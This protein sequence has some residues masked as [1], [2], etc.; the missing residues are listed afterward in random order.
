MDKLAVPNHLWKDKRIPM[1]AK[2]VYAYLYS[3]RLDQTI[4]YLNVGDI[5]QTISITNIG[6]RKCLEKLEKF[7]YLIYKECDT[8]MYTIH[9]N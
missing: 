9:I 4:Q 5:Q 6:L 2:Y 1:D 7:K 8:G 3:K